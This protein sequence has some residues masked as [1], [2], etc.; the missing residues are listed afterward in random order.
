[1][2]TPFCTPATNVSSV[3]CPGQ[4]GSTSSI[5]AARSWPLVVNSTA[6][7]RGS[8]VA[9]PVTAIWP[10]WTGEAVTGTVKSSCPLTLMWPASRRAGAEDGR[11]KMVT[12]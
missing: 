7:A 9:R 2:T 11:A 12:R 5:P 3:R 1:M 6:S 8:S 10:G 4:A